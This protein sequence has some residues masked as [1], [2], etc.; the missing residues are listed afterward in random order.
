MWI[1]NTYRLMI[2]LPVLIMSIGG[3]SQ[4]VE[5]ALEAF[6]RQSDVTTANRFFE[7]LDKHDF[8]DNLIVF[9]AD[10]A[11]DSL[12]LQVWYWAAEWFY[13]CQQYEQAEAYGLKAKPLSEVRGQEQIHGDLLS[14]LE[15]EIGR[16]SCRERV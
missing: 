10:K 5:T 14:L 16:A 15:I 9:N 11:T 8:T 6:D 1:S 7:E 2:L 4:S 12:C 13:D 3:W